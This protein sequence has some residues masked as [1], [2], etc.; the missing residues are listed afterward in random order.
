MEILIGRAARKL[1]WLSRPRFEDPYAVIP[2]FGTEHPKQKE[3][4]IKVI[5]ELEKTNQA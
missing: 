2:Y 1:K 4:P 3:M 5:R